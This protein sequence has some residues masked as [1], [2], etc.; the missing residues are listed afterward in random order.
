MRGFVRTLGQ[1]RKVLFIG[2]AIAGLKFGYLTPLL[3]GTDRLLNISNIF[4]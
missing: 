1:R 3:A 2:F 4:T